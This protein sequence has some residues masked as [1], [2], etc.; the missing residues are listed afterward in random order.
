MKINITKLR[1]AG[2]SLRKDV[3]ENDEIL[4]RVKD[5]FE[6]IKLTEKQQREKI[7]KDFE[8]IKEKC[9]SHVGYTN[10]RQVLS[11]IKQLLKGEKKNG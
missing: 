4:V 8:E 7:L 5:L 10:Y 3:T 1:E 11:Q 9:T 2:F 6:L